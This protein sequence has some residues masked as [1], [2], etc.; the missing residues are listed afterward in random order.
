VR[1]NFVDRMLAQVDGTV[2]PI[3]I[4]QLI[5]TDAPPSAD[6]LR[7]ALTV[8][9]GE[10]ERLQLGWSAERA[11]WQPMK[12]GWRAI[13][14]AVCSPSTLVDHAAAVAEVLARPID[15]SRDLPLR[16]TIQPLLA[17]PG[18]PAGHTLI[19]IQLHHAIGDARSLMYVNQRLWQLVGGVRTG[20]SCLGPAR[21]SDGQA[22]RAL[23]RRWPA[24]PAITQAR[25]RVLARRG[26]ALRRSGDEV[27]APM[28]RS[29][30]VPLDVTAPR[31]AQLFFGA[32]LAGIA[33]HGLQDGS[34]PVRFRVPVD[35]RRE[36]GIG[37]TLENACSAV[38]IEVPLDALANAA[39]HDPMALG[40]YVPDQLAAL[41]RAGVHWA[42]LLECVTVAR[43]ASAETL[44][45]HTRPELLARRR[46]STMVTT[47]A[48]SVDRYFA[49]VPFPI[50]TMRTHTPTWGANAFGF[51]GALVINVGAFDRLWRPDEI[52][53]FVAAMQAWLTVVGRPA[54]VL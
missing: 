5:T 15:L 9:A 50:R 18:T 36:L 16:I 32:L 45:R 37:R 20:A 17:G 40:R 43:L 31:A 41:L 7:A 34:A 35:L 12:R 11:D 51:G 24:L 21:L 2:A 19:A 38:P 52:D 22:L 44:R 4:T 27:G 25:H 53:G 33:A 26:A 54:E 30:R 46:G 29:L 39:A 47:Y 6:A 14:H 3:W 8:L 28:L 1:A 10:V 23:A 42:T 13:H 48:G 49:E